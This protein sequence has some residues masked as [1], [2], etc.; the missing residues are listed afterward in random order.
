MAPAS[1]STPE[2]T[3]FLLTLVDEYLE[4]QKKGRLVK[5]WVRLYGEWFQKWEITEDATIEDAAERQKALG[6]AIQAKK[7]VGTNPAISFDSTTLTY[8]FS[9]SSAGT[10]IIHPEKRACFHSDASPNSP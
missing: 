6:E 3:K 2:Q 1:K 5:F 4:A 10:Q 8:K 9:I 7:A